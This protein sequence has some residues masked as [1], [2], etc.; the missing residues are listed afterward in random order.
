MISAFVAT[1][2]A[3]KLF[4][5]GL[6]LIAAFFTIWYAIAS[7]NNWVVA[8]ALDENDKAW[9]LVVAEVKDKHLAYIAE[10]DAIRA[11]IVADNAKKV[12]DDQLKY[13]QALEEVA[14]ISAQR[15]SIG[16]NHASLT[17]MLDSITAGSA[18]TTGDRYCRVISGFRD[19]LQKCELGFDRALKIAGQEADRARRS[20][21]AAEALKRK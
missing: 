12:K 18:C 10:Q 19:T 20:S 16:R 3:S 21:A 15:D 7:Y 5:Q 6:A 2:W 17:S 4:R 14:K 11:Q 1:L 13:N 9:E 8:D